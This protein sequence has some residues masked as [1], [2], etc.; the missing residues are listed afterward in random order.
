[1]VTVEL[2][3]AV[4]DVSVRVGDGATWEQAQYELLEPHL[5]R[6]ADGQATA[7]ALSPQGVP[8]AVAEAARRVRGQ[9]TAAAEEQLR[10]AT[11]SADAVALLDWAG[12]G[13]LPL[14]PALLTEAGRDLLG[15]L[16]TVDL[17]GT[18][19][20]KSQRDQVARIARCWPAVRAGIATHLVVLSDRDPAAVW[21]AMSGLAGT[22]L[23]GE[24]LADSPLRVPYLAWQEL[25]R[26]EAPVLILGGMARRGDITAT[27]DLL[28]AALWPTGTWSI[29]DASRVLAE[30]D[31]RVLAGALGWF[32]ETLAAVPARADA[33]RYARL[34]DA[35]VGSPLAGQL[36]AKDRPA[37]GKVAELH[38]SLAAARSVRDLLPI[39]KRIRGGSAP[40]LV[41]ASEWLPPEAARLPAAAPGE[42]LDA[43]R[44][45]P[46]P[47]AHRYLSAAR[48][49]FASPDAQTA[50]QAAAFWLIARNRGGWARAYDDRIG[51]ILRYVARW[52]PR[53]RL[54]QTATMLE[55]ERS[56]AGREFRDWA[57]LVRSGRFAWLVRVIRVLRAL[58]PGRPA[59]AAAKPASGGTAGRER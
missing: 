42:V 23:A 4:R 44:L 56:G 11:D 15:P 40:L 34:C 28:L 16:L 9:L 24:D 14:G 32:E 36:P 48:E 35:L 3:E 51:E 29:A 2:R 50:A 47:I 21:S 54:D 57:G 30:V 58:R 6:R 25:R 27:D 26:G 13:R 18:R 49:R 38:Q 8:E 17:D 1:M 43:V 5:R 37:L 19:L 55:A 12:Q 39:I 20:S 46:P 45:M 59:L 33:P 22:V 31:N 7:A 52:W 53:Y 10:L 41:L